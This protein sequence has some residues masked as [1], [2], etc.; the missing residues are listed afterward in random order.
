MMADGIGSPEKQDLRTSGEGYYANA[1]VGR[2]RRHKPRFSF[3]ICALA[4]RAVAA[5]LGRSSGLTPAVFKS[6]A[7]RR[8]ASYGENLL[9]VPSL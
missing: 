4:S 7:Y 9:G 1:F 3:S 8:L 6:G 5:R 2:T